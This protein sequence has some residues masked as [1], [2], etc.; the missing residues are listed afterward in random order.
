MPLHHL[1]SS[2]VH[3]NFWVQLFFSDPLIKPVGSQNQTI[4]CFNGVLISIQ[5]EMPVDKIPVKITWV[6]KMLVGLGAGWTTCCKLL[7]EIYKRS[8][9]KA[10]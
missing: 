7:K 10:I 5:D 1:I 9:T 2:S 6:N 4:L 8:S 3:N